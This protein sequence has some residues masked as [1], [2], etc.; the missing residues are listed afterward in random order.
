MKN[1]KIHIKKINFKGVLKFPNKSYLLKKKGPQ[2]NTLDMYLKNS[3]TKRSPLEILK[4]KKSEEQER[5]IYKI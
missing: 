5:Y 1:T 3:K 2:N 4:E